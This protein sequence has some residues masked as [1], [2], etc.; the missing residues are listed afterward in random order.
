MPLGTLDRSPPPFFRQGPSA[1]TKLVFCATLALFLMVAD[2]RFEVAQTLRAVIATALHPVQRALLAPV[3]LWHGGAGYLKGLSRALADADA[4]QRR[5]A[6]QAEQAARA[7]RLDTE[8]ARLRDLLG[9]RPALLVRSLAAEVLYEATDPFSRKIVVD[10][11]TTHGVVPGAPVINE[12]GVLGQVTR[13]FPLTSE[14]TLLTDR[15]AT[16]PVLN[17]RTQQRAVAFGGAGLE[18]RFMPDNADVQVDDLLLTSG[19]DGVYPPGL[20]VARVRQVER[21][22]ESGFARIDLVTAAAADGARH[23]LVLEPLGLQLPARPAVDA[24]TAAPREP[25]ARRRVRK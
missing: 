15:S 22:A 17:P 18:L 12:E 1:L 2:T 24:A 13:A 19:V 4:A 25:A 23:V 9:L 10:R 5:L 8:N 11:G 7:T 16:I 20:P 6:A 21:R 14:V 3:E